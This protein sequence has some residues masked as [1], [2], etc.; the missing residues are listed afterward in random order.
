MKTKNVG[1]RKGEPGASPRVAVYPGTFDPITLGHIDV[2]ARGAKIFD[3]LIVGVAVKTLKKPMFSLK[4]R[5]EM[6]RNAVGH[7]KNVEVEGFTGLVVE[8]LRRHNSRIILRGMR[9]ASDFEYEY[10]I[11]LTNRALAADV[12]TI[13]LMPGEHYTFI[14]SSIIKNVIISGGDAGRLVTAEVNRK[15]KKKLLGRK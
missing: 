5:V 14:S 1:K 15:L 13:F 7:I 8:L 4:E 12:E 9:T 6:A 3:R 10:Q 11:A 2:I